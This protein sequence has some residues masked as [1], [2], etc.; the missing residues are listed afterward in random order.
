MDVFYTVSEYAEIMGKDPGNIRR[1]LI[2][3]LIPGQKLGKQWVIPKDSVYPRDQRVK[4]G[5]YRNWRKKTAVRQENLQLMKGI[6]KMCRDLGNL[7]GT[8]LDRIVLYGSYARGEASEESDVDIALILRR[9][10]TEKKHAAMTDIVV[11]Y[12]L[13]CGKTLSVITI[14][15]RQYSSWR[16]TLPFY[17]NME[18]EGIIL[19]KTA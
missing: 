15:K 16:E 13:E 2:K 17:T 14:D 11:D 18:K 9:P 12:E 6:G 3:G 8:T 7:Y 5:D 10:E 1:N 19:W 4:T